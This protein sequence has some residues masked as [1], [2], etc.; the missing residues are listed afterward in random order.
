METLLAWAE[1]GFCQAGKL[2]PAGG[3]TDA[4]VA[5]VRVQGGDAGAGYSPCGASPRWGWREE[6]LRLPK[7]KTGT[8]TSVLVALSALAASYSNSVMRE[9]RRNIKAKQRRSS[10]KLEERSRRARWHLVNA[11]GGGVGWGA[12]VLIMVKMGSFL[13]VRL[14]RFLEFGE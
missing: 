3:S 6:Q 7:G 8:R 14:C 1:K 11:W 4:A 13:S 5:L 2:L 9:R 10:L 12:I